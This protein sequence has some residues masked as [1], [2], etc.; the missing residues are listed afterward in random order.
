[1]PTHS[2]RPTAEIDSREAVIGWCRRSRWT[3]ASSRCLKSDG[4]ITSC[5]VPSREDILSL[6]ATC[7]AAVVCTRSLGN[8][9]RV[10]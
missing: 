6:S 8:A 5:V 9:R 1:L 4:E 7:P 10:M 2:G 3:A